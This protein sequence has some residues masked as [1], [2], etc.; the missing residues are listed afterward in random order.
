MKA[1]KITKKLD[2]IKEKISALRE[3]EQ[4]IQDSIVEE[5]KKFLVTSRA[6][7]IDFDV[8]V[9]GLLEVIQK[10]K[11]NDKSVEV[12]KQSGVTFRK[13]M[14]RNRPQS[15]QKPSEKVA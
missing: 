13:K 14:S 5:F 11:S 3:E 9:G 10:S 4:K 12:W 15:T 2:S 6:I 1:E 7:E 8:I